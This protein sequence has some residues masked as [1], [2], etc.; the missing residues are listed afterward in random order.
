MT[1]DGTRQVGLF[2]RDA[3]D[4]TGEADRLVALGATRLRDLPDGIELA[5]PDGNEFR[6]RAG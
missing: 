4:P 2:W 3:A 6:L 5:D 1:C